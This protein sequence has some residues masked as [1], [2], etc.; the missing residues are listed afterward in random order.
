MCNVS[1]EIFHHRKGRKVIKT[2]NESLH[3]L[4]NACLHEPVKKLAKLK[5]LECKILKQIKKIK[6]Y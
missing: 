4:D 6:K 1:L 2:S 5:Q 3:H